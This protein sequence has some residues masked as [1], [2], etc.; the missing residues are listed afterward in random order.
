MRF[1]KKE[2]RQSKAM[3]LSVRL[4]GLEFLKNGLLVDS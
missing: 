1:R 3:P 4:D 2:V